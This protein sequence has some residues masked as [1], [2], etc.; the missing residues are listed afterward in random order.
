MTAVVVVDAAAVTS[1]AV[2]E[3]VVVVVTVADADAGAT[4]IVAQ[5]LIAKPRASLQFQTGEKLFF[6]F[7]FRQPSIPS[8]FPLVPFTSTFTL[9]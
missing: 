8:P 9:H 2:T 4:K 7:F 6:L 5:L 3:T 1:E